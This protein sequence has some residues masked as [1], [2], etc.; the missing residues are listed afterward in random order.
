MY[1]R[2]EGLNANDF[3]NNRSGIDRPVLIRNT[4]GGAVGGPIIKDKLFFFYSYEERRDASQTP[5]DPRDVPLPSLGRG[6]GRYVEYG[7][8]F[9]ASR[10]FGIR[11]SLRGYYWRV[12]LRPSVAVE[13]PLLRRAGRVWVPTWWRKWLPS[14]MWES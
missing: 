13:V 6:E 9:G 5:S 3:F 14:H 2:H 4:F 1:K 7:T 11:H 12:V 10:A 8:S